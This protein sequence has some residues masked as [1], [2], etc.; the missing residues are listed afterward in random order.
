M[1]MTEEARV[2]GDMTQADLDAQYDQHTQIPDNARYVERWDAWRAK[3][4]DFA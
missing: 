1:T 2:F 4:R 3:V